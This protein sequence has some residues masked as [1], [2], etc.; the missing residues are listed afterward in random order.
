MD[1]KKVKTLVVSAKWDVTAKH[2]FWHWLPERLEMVQSYVLPHLPPRLM[3][4]YKKNKQKIQHAQTQQQIRGGVGSV[5]TPLWSMLSWLP[6]PPYDIFVA[7]FRKKGHWAWSHLLYGCYRGH[8]LLGMK[9]L[10]AFGGEQLTP[11]S[12][13]EEDWILLEQ[14]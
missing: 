2:S 11:Y 3:G 1:D 14:K 5:H 10:W 7:L 9:E 6:F 13:E 8:N 12:L 4:Y